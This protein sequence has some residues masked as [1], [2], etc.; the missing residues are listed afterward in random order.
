MIHQLRI[1]QVDPALVEHF[2]E[3]FKNHA[4]RIMERHGFHIESMWYSRDNGRVEFVYVL[5]WP[6]AEQMTTRWDAF[7]ADPEW[8]AIKQRS[9]DTTGEPVIAKLADKVLTD[10]Y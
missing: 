7:M 6:D 4:K 10:S 3:R 5:R 8:E 2:D 1:Y 9:R